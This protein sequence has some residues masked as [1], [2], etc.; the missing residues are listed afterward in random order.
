MNQTNEE[1]LPLTEK[2]KQAILVCA[3]CALALI[4]TLTVTLVLVNKRVKASQQPEGPSVPGIHL[5]DAFHL[6]SEAVLPATEDAGKPYLD[7]TLFIGDSNTVRIYNNGLISLQ[8]ML[9]KEGLSI[10]EAASKKFISF[11]RDSQQYTIPEAVAKLKPRRVVITLGTNDAG[12]QMTPEMFAAD[13]KALVEAIQK[14]YPYTDIIINAIPP[15]PEDHSKY[16]LPQQKYVDEMNTALVTMCEE[17][18]L[19]FLNSTEALKNAEGF[20]RDEFFGK[21]DIH[22]TLSGVQALLD[23]HTTHAWETE[24]RRPDTN[25]IAQQVE[26]FGSDATPRPTVE[27]ETVYTASYNTQ[28]IDTKDNAG[29]TLTGGEQSGKTALEMQI[30]SSDTA[31]TVRAV[32]NPGYVFVKWSDGSSSMERTDKNFTQ[33]LDVTAMFAPVNL[34]VSADKEKVKAGEEIKLTANLNSENYARSADIIWFDG[35]TKLDGTGASCTFKPSKAGTLDL[36]AEVKYNGQ[37][38][39]SNRIKVEV[40]AAAKP[41]PTDAPKPN[42]PAPTTAPTEAPKPAPTKEP[43]PAPTKAPT[44]AP[45][46]APAPAPT[47]APETPAPATPAPTD[48]APAPGENEL[49]IVPIG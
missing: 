12:G 25:N 11:Q 21:G 14:S 1:K 23:Y 31:V 40:E 15:M 45:T 34:T 43:T 33:N 7:D 29:G 6:D 37:T 22:L 39:A 42:T 35:Q 36:Y 17:M 3:I 2:Q 20:G 28:T 18:D 5:E 8:Q 49:P 38:V 13:Y 32:P 48:A 41:K 47:A 46:D 24:D 27:P 4:I 26:S 19:K 44:P 9:A 30:K 10:T 16:P